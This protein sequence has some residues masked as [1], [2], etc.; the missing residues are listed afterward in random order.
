[1]DIDFLLWL[2][3]LRNAVNSPE[4]DNFMKI[5]SK[6]GIPYAFFIFAFIYWSINKRSG[7]YITTSW[8][9]SY[10]FMNFIKMTACAYRPFMRNSDIMPLDNSD[11]YSFP[12]SHATSA[13][14]IAGGMS[15]CFWK[16]G[17]K[18]L[19]WLLILLI[20]LVGFS[21]L[22]L[23]VHTPQDIIAGFLLG[24]VTLW[25]MSKIFNYVD[26]HKS[27]ENL[28]LISGVVICALMLVYLHNKNYPMDYGANNKLIVD[29]FKEIRSS[30]RDVG[31]VSGL[32]LGR[33][34][35]KCF[36]KFRATGLNF[37][38][39]I[40]SAAGLVIFYFILNYLQPFLTSLI[41]NLYGRFAY[42]FI[43]LFF[44]TALWPAVIKIFQ[45]N[46]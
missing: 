46:K 9:F 4:L 31:V 29:P 1:M 37:K 6:L 12:S 24:A 14:S 15:V 2:Q 21:R 13:A 43:E 16:A 30:W 45:G 42:G 33:F 27:S 20:I 19:S 8:A 40:L 44:V 41:G 17:Y 11:G 3:N 28:F 38:G 32:V 36:I 18:L 5:L 39:I 26:K 22:Y 34:V 25:I 7:L 10:L 35:E 23:G